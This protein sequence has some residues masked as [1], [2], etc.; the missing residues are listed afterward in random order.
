MITIGS[1]YC[2]DLTFF[3]RLKEIC[4]MYFLQN[5]FCWN[6]LLIL[7]THCWPW[8][9]ESTLFAFISKR[10]PSNPTNCSNCLCVTDC[11][12]ALSQGLVT[13]AVKLNKINS[14][15]NNAFSMLIEQSSKYSWCP[16]KLRVLH[17][18]KS[19]LSF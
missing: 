5:F 19:Y 1:Q 14:F 9:M 18:N 8:R 12:A 11:I 10:Y 3:P 6:F 4:S 13:L 17:Q 2:F 7:F 16:I 15:E